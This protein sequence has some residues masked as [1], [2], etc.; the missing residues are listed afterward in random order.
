MLRWCGPGAYNSCGL[1]VGAGHP[2]SS[3]LTTLGGGDPGGGK[4]LLPLVCSSWAKAGGGRGLRNHRIEICGPADP[5]AFCSVGILVV[6]LPTNEGTYV[7]M[8]TEVWVLQ[9]SCEAPVGTASGGCPIV[10]F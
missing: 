10:S 6:G 4:L 1:L 2:T 8:W 3:Q 7:L 9:R 5:A